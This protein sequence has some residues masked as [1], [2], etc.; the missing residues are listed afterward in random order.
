[1]Q[2]ISKNELNKLVERISIVYNDLNNKYIDFQEAGK[3]VDNIENDFLDK[4]SGKTPIL[5][6]F[7]FHSFTEWSEVKNIRDDIHWSYQM[8]ICKKCGLCKVRF[9]I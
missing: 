9:I 4:Y 1:M 2:Y 8:K 3:R 7:H 6:K 5:C